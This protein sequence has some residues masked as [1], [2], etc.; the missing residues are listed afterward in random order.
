MEAT[1]NSE[2][3]ALTAQ[4]GLLDGELSSSGPEAQVA[5]A[6]ADQQMQ[7]QEQ[8]T[9]QVRLIF[10]LAVPVLGRLYPSIADI[11]TDPTCDQLATVLG[12][13]LTKYGINL[14]DMGDK[15]GVEIA[16]VMVCGPVAM[17]T[18]HGIQADIAGRDES[19]RTEQPP[20]AVASNRQEAPQ[21][22]PE[23]VSLG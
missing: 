13:L 15:W 9:G 14:G 17:A 16:A 22:T 18:Y 1:E 6:E 19:M 2:L 10:A 5:Q 12:P 3:A 4:A 23:M 20:K 11:Y 21:M 8:N 7:Q